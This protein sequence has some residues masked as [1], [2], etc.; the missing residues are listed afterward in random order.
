M[1]HVVGIKIPSNEVQLVEEVE[2]TLKRLEG[3]PL[4]SL[5]STI[6]S[7]HNFWA[8]YNELPLP[9]LRR[10]LMCEGYIINEVNMRIYLP[11]KSDI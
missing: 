2:S 7:F 11:E 4:S 5:Y 1:L 8:Y 3:T 10:Y 9:L 6:R